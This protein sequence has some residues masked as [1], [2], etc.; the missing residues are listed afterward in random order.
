MKLAFFIAFLASGDSKLIP[1]LYCAAAALGFPFKSYIFGKTGIIAP[2]LDLRGK[3]KIQP[4][5]RVFLTLVM[6]TLRKQW[7]CA[8]DPANDDIG[9]DLEELGEQTKHQFHN[10][11]A[12]GKM[13]LL[14]KIFRIDF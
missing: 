6:E 11:P 14:K 13:I 8:F 10:D 12:L 2:H 5:E 1:W 3:E 9:M 4:R 7:R